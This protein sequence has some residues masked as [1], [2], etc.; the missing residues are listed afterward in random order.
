M[1][2][3]LGG[4]H[5]DLGFAYRGFCGFCAGLSRA[6]LWGFLGGWCPSA[7]SEIRQSVSVV[8]DVIRRA[9][10]RPR[11]TGRG[12]TGGPQQLGFCVGCFRGFRTSWRASKR[13]RVAAE[14][15]S[16]FDVAAARPCVFWVKTGIVESWGR[17]GQWFVLVLVCK[18][19]LRGSAARGKI[20]V[21]SS[22]CVSLDCF[23]YFGPCPTRCAR[24]K[25]IWGARRRRAGTAAAIGRLAREIAALRRRSRQQGKRKRAAGDARLGVRP[26]ASASITRGPLLLSRDTHTHT[27]KHT[28]THSTAAKARKSHTHKTVVAGVSIWLF[29]SHHFFHCSCCICA[30]LCNKHTNT[31]CMHVCFWL[32][33]TN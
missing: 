10:M 8:F 28:Q 20:L 13:L 33:T 7:S 27:H 17:V 24:R 21:Y 6:L 3:G 26:R 31:T 22:S 12:P 15:C 32:G 29:E 14:L 4:V 25:G 11:K 1:G 5:F 2:W 19:F 18:N 23:F 30:H 16:C 9:T